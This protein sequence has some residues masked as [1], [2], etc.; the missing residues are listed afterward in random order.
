MQ[1][2]LYATK[3]NLILPKVSDVIF[4]EENEND[5]I[6]GSSIVGSNRRILQ[7]NQ[8]WLDMELKL[9]DVVGV[10]GVE[11]QKTKDGKDTYWCVTFANN[12][13]NRL[14]HLRQYGYDLNMD[15]RYIAV[16]SGT[17]PYRGN[18]VK[19]VVDFNRKDGFLKQERQTTEMTHAECYAPLSSI[20][21]TDGQKGL[22]YYD[23]P[24]EF[25][26]RADNGFSILPYA[27]TS[28]LLSALVFSPLMVTVDGSYDMDDDGLIGQS[29]K[30][31][32]YN[33][34]VVL[35]G[36]QYDGT[37]IKWWDVK[38]SETKQL[39]KFRPDYRFGWPC[40]KDLK[41]KN[42]RLFKKKGEPAIYFLNPAD[43]ML[44][45]YSDGVITG[46]SLFK[47]IFGDYKYAPIEYVDGLPFPKADYEWT[48]KKI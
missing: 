7:P 18:S 17:V 16:G 42:M 23:F 21:Y 48:T 41:K 35:L 2:N 15:E 9:R 34:E 5:Y 46:G 39:L 32:N 29:G 20:D 30:V 25:L 3:D 6:F 8:S 38:C 4:Y 28:I 19:A 12:N 27:E 47:I 14:L 13:V 1:D 22:D 43:N 11:I 26:P 40:L 10:D 45:P 33:H 44:M 37:R 36:A 31:L 24:Y